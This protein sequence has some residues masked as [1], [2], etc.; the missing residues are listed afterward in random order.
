MDLV[1]PGRLWP[2][3]RDTLSPTVNQIVDA[4]SEERIGTT[5]E[6]AGG[7]R[8][9]LHSLR[10]R[11]P[12]PRNRRGAALPPATGRVYSNEVVARTWSPGSSASG[13]LI[14]P[15]DTCEAQFF[16]GKTTS[17]RPTNRGAP[18]G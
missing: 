15:K 18:S 1:C 17:D 5:M 8:D 7:V 2:A 9:P 12:N 4:V 3:S 16:V 13:H 11:Q 6:E 14:R 10:A